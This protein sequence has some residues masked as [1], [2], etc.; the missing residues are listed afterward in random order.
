MIEIEKIDSLNTLNELKK[1]Y[2]DQATAPLDGM[3][4][5]G[6]VPMA[7]HWGFYLKSKLVGFCCINEDNYMLQFY[8]AP[9]CQV[10]AQALFT[11]IAQKNSSITGEI[12]GAFVSTAEPYYMSLCLDNS[13]TFTVNALMYQLAQ[14]RVNNKSEYLTMEL[15]TQEQL[16]NFVQFAVENIGAPQAWVSGYYSHL[17]AREEL[18]GY[19]HK[20][21]LLAS[22]EC[23]LFEEYQTEYAEL[24]MIVSQAERGQGI[25]ESVLRYLINRA[26]NKGLKSICSTESNN[27][28]AQKAICRAGLVPDN[29]IVKFEFNNI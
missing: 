28:G 14:K 21:Q 24:G 29:R 16:S 9:K 18:Y 20:G 4:H 26:S 1:A 25:G 13:A 11:L 8:I 12:K 5:F 7:K 15:A 10:Y 22:G 19:W 27:I 6:F 23:R 17:I 2:F 3:W